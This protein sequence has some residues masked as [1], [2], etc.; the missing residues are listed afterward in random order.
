MDAD[1]VE[2]LGHGHHI[3]MLSTRL[4][5]YV[6]NTVHHKAPLLVPPLRHPPQVR[7]TLWLTM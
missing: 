3:K 4:Q 2:L 7:H 1:T 6:T 5:E